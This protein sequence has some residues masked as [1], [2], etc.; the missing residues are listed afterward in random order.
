MGSDSWGAKISPV[1]LQE[2]VAEGA[3]TVLPKRASV[4]GEARL[5]EA[6]QLLREGP[7][8]PSH[9]CNCCVPGAAA[10]DRYFKSRSLSNN[11]RNAWFAEFWEENFG[12]KLGTHGKRVGGARRCTGTR[13]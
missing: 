4:D 6:S 8:A 9:T 7:G 13:G 1:I 10:F 11:R 5:G 3:I 2:E 12:C